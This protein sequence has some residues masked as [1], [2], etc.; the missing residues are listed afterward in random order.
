MTVVFA[1]DV[2]EE[3]E[4]NLRGIR[5]LVETYRD[6]LRGVIAVDGFSTEH[7]T[8]AAL[9]SR[10]IEVSITG[11]GGHSWSD[12]GVPNPITALSR[13]IVRFSAVRVAASPRTTFNVGLIEGGTSV[14]SIPARAAARVDIRSEDEAEI[15]RVNA[16]LESAV[17]A[18]IA[19]EMSA[20]SGSDKLEG[21]FR[22]LGM[23]PGGK[24][25]DDAP[26]LAA[27]RSADRFLNNR[28]RLEQASTDAN[29]PLSMG[30]P[31]LAIGGGGDG[32]GAHSLAEWYDPSG[33]E[34]GLKRAL[35]AVLTFAG[36]QP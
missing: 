23:R 16:A 21:H 3:G 28:S 4:G 7:V 36:V 6:R 19:D 14:N 9:A 2:G 33:R 34:L 15:L 11:P 5:Q 22:M 18:G 20:A 35:L 31:A 12:F 1:A 24:L 27:L 25:P 29:L 30:I 26:L 8:T 10:R 13:A 17:R 32:G